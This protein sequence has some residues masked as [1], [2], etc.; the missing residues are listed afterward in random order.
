MG[1][2][3]QGVWR[4]RA[5]YDSDVT[6]DAKLANV[7]AAQMRI[8]LDELLQNAEA[9]LAGSSNP[10]IKITASVIARK[11]T[12]KRVLRLEVIDNVTCH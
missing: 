4:R 8:L 1:Y 11:F 3:N 6:E 2:P 5:D 7:P 12:R 10:Q 9:A